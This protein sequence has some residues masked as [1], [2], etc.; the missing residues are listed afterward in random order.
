M[1]RPATTWQAFISATENA[2]ARLADC[3]LTAITHPGEA[4]PMHTH[5]G[6]HI[7]FMRSG[8]VR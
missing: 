5:P 3:E 2:A 8:R 4:S 1:N 7:I 6:N